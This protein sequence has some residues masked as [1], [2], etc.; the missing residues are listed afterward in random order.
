M[1]GQNGGCR[2][3]SPWATVMPT[4]E[5]TTRTLSRSSASAIN[6]EPSSLEA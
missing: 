2:A 3:A 5:V 1:I 4:P 6:S